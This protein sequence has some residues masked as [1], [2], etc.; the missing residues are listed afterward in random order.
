V[1]WPNSYGYNMFLYPFSRMTRIYYEH[2]HRLL[3]RWWG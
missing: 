1:D 3:G 2:A